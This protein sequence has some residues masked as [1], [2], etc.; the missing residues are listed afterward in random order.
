M[1]LATDPNAPPAA[2]DRAALFTAP[3]NHHHVRQTTTT[4]NLKT[5]LPFLSWQV[6]AYLAI[7]FYGTLTDEHLV[8]VT[9]ANINLLSALPFLSWR[10]DL[11]V[12]NTQAFPIHELYGC[13]LHGV[14]C[15]NAFKAQG[16]CEHTATPTKLHTIFTKLI[17]HG[18]DLSQSIDWA[19]GELAMVAA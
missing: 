6:D 11:H 15:D 16:V 3:T 18:L 2:G 9:D 8:R 10:A 5:A 17:Q 14:T 13:L 1:E 12:P 7:A 4:I 19:A